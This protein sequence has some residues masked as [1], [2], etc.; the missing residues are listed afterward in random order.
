M[1]YSPQVTLSGKKKKKKK[2]CQCRRPKI[3][4]FDP[5]VEKIPWRRARQPI[6]VFL[7]G[8]SQEEPGGL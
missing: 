6:P 2:S 3:C 1:S 8:E 7:S 4:R 5:W